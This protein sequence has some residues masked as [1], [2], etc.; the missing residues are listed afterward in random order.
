M[1]GPPSPTPSDGSPPPATVVIVPLVETSRIRLF[2]P[3][4][5]KRF[6]EPSRA[7][8]MPKLPLNSAEIA[9]PPSPENPW[10]PLPATVLMMPLARTS[11][12]RSLLA[13]AIKRFP[14]A[15]TVTPQGAL[16]SAEIA[17]PPSPENPWDPLPATVVMMPLVE[18]FRIRLLSWS[19]MKRFP[20]ASTEIP[21]G[22]DSDA[23]VANPPSPENPWFPLP[24]MVVMMPLVETLRIRLLK[25][26]AMKRLP[27]ASTVTPNG[28]AKEAEV[29]GPP[30]PENPRV[31]PAKVVMIPPAD[32]FWIRSLKVSAMN[33]SPE[34]SVATPWGAY[35]DANVAN[36][37]SP[38]KPWFPLPAT[39]VMVP[40]GTIGP[41]PGRTSVLLPVRT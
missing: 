22:K 1:A 28:R 19:P 29:A 40:P 3:S 35:R 34:A 41:T 30:S 17:G 5:M 23:D 14:E 12:I 24:A 20:E 38:E 26:S 7:I 2:R 25:V 9:G 15:S 11:R 31:P 10:D 4:V 6:P 18:T 36:P 37:P 33:R 27:E 8:S 13:S 39:V 32:T 21:R 16:N